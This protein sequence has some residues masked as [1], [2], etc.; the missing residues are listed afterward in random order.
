MAD[1]QTE[2]GQRGKCIRALVSFTPADHAEWK[3]RA[4]EAKDIEAPPRQLS[5]PGRFARPAEQF[6]IKRPGTST[7]A[8]PDRALE[9]NVE[10]VFRRP[11][12][13]REGTGR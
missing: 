11:R 5:L 13:V 10:D 8:N 1:D 7:K 12:L 2:Q 3:Q 9:A 4:T 6:A